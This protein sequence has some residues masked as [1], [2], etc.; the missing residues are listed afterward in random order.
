MI[1]KG[2]IQKIAHGVQQGVETFG[3]LKGLYTAGRAAF[4]VGRTLGAAAVP[5]LL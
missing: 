2:A 4:A 3:A 1:N 5:F